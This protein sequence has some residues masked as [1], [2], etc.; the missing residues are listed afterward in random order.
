MSPASLAMGYEI[1]VT[2]LQLAAAYVR[3]RER[4]ATC[5][6]RR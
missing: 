2:P 4:R 3:D 6:S 5:S 1:A